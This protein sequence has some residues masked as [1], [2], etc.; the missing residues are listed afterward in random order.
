[1]PPKGGK[2]TPVTPG[3]IERI[4]TGVAYIIAGADSAWMGPKQP[5]KPVAQEAVGRQFDYQVGFNTQFTPRAGT[6]VSFEDLVGLA[7]TCD[8][9]RILIEDRKDQLESIKWQIREKNAPKGQSKKDDPAIK[10]IEAFFARPDR[11]YDWKQW[12][13]QIIEEM[14]VT[15]AVSVYRR[16]NKGEKPYAF[17]LLDGTTISPKVDD[18]GRI[19]M[20]PEVAYQ[21]ILKGVPAVDYSAAELLYYPRNVRVRSVYGYSPVEQMIVTINIAIRRSLHQLQYYTEGNVPDAL[22]GTPPEWTAEMVQTF[23]KYWDSIYMGNT[24]QRRKGV[25]VPGSAKDIHEIVQPPLKD[26]YD[27]WIA[28]IACFC[29]KVSPQPF[30]AQVN[31]A[32]AEVAQASSQESGLVA[33]K[34][35]VKSMMD[36]FIAED[37]QRPD[38]EFVWNAEEEQDPEVESRVLTSYAKEA[39]LTRNEVRERLG[40]DPDPNPNASRLGFTTGSGFVPLDMTPEEKAEKAAMQAAMLDGPEEEGGGEEDDQEEGSSPEKA[41]KLQKKKRKATRTSMERQVV[42]Y[43]KQAASKKVRAVLADAATALAAQLRHLEKTELSKSAEDDAAQAA[44]EIVLQ[45]DLEK[46]K[47]LEGAITDSLITVANDAARQSLKQMGVEAGSPIF[48]RASKRATAYARDRAAE[49]VTEIDET[50]RDMLRTEIKDALE[51]GTTRRDLADKL[52]ELYA[53]SDERADLIAGTEIA[54]AN[55]AGSLDAYEAAAETGLIVKKEWILG[56]EP[57][58]I[59]QAN[60]D[61]GPIDLDEKFPSGDETTPAHPRCECAVSPVVEE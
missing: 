6:G 14:L 44:S 21:Q 18:T 59:C 46:L 42:K 34:E 58:E 31:R 2:E 5:L 57:C 15:D 13:R 41:E 12:L 38:L 19:P 9:V 37:F 8:I 52:S 48:G 3:L 60:A 16:R 35:Y 56:P 40:L 33:T 17:E 11:I 47:E 27:E 45:L 43:A 49:L 53:F 7:S 25:F 32:T 10:E 28:R 29:F 30:V 20:P 26:Q 22:I 39:V 24:G 50:T 4:R 1:M 23:Q 61:A 54:F 36:R 51:A 55:G